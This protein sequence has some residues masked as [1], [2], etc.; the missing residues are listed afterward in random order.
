VREI[1]FRSLGVDDLQS[2]FLW[3]LRPHVAKWY[4][5]APGSFPEIV[6][7][8]GPR[9]QRESPVHAYV[10]VVDGKDIGYIQSYSLDEFPDYA[11]RLA[12][13]PGVAG[14]DLF[15]GEETSLGW[16]LGARA[17]RHFVDRH[18]FGATPALACI[19]GTQ[20]GNHAAIR[21]FE[22]AGFVR[23]KV[24]ENERGERECVMRRE[25]IPTRFRL[26]PIDID[27][28]LENCVAFRREMYV[29]SFGSEDG[30]EEEMGDGDSIYIAQLRERV[31]QLPEGNTHLWDGDR[32]VG[33][34]EMR[35]DEEPGVGYVSLFYLAP[36]F[37]G[38]GLGRMLHEYAVE[39]CKARGLTRMRL[40]VA[41]R[42]SA[43]IDFY[44]GLGWVEAGARPHRLPMQL[45]E[46][47]I[48]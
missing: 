34:T 12:V 35:L 3:L 19:G 45:M 43:A 10:I 15:I 24:V 25:R 4:A 46:F 37:R 39:I 1:T 8:Y 30:L 5:R 23:W 42:N 40:S 32:I 38:Q 18:V 29:A 27:R 7:K 9:T 11:A 6:A 17:I 20:D 48:P 16:G 31:E 36:E 13:E 26:A 22:R 28:H 47:A 33:Q 14:L 21:A 2:M 44:R 41:S